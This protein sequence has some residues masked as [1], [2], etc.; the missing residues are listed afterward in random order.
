MPDVPYHGPTHEDDGSD[1]SRG[2]LPYI[3]ASNNG[4]SQVVDDDAELEFAIGTGHVKTNDPSTFA[5]DPDDPA[6]L[7]V[8]RNGLYRV[9]S[10][11]NVNV[12]DQADPREIYVTAQLLS[13]GPLFGLGAAFGDGGLFQLGPGQG[14]AGVSVVS[15]TS[16][17]AK[18][19]LSYIAM[20]EVF[21]SADAPM[22]FATILQHLTNDYTLDTLPSTLVV[23]RAG[24]FGSR[25]PLPPGVEA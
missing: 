5:F 2:W 11:V 17:I 20:G 1:P 18:A 3:R 10:T 12:G 23:E 19:S 22:R 25:P 16:T 14:P 4:A 9:F 24:G 7:V 8:I 6:G 21:A 13:N 15:A